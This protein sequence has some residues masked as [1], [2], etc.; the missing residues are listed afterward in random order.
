[1]SDKRRLTVNLSVQNHKGKRGTET[2]NALKRLALMFDE[3]YVTPPVANVINST[4]LEKPEH[5]TA[6]DGRRLLDASKFNYFRDTTE[7][8]ELVFDSFSNQELR[9]TLLVFREA[10]I[11]KTS[12]SIFDELPKEILGL[13]NRLVSYDITDK[14]FNRLSRTKPSDYGLGK[15]YTITLM[16]DGDPEKGEIVVHVLEDPPAVSDSKTITRELITS[17]HLSSVPVFIEQT[18]RA[19]IEYKYSQ[20]KEGLKILRKSH[21][22][23]L[24]ELD[25]KAKLGEVAFLVS[26]ELFDGGALSLCSPEEVVRY[27]SAMEEARLKYVSSDLVNVASMIKDGPWSEQSRMEVSKYINGKLNVDLKNYETQSKMTYRKFFGQLSTHATGVALGGGIGTLLGSVIPNASPWS[28][29]L[30]GSLVGAAR[31]G[32]QIVKSIVDMW[33]QK[34]NDRGSAI[35]F[36]AEFESKTS[37]KRRKKLIGLTD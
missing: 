37:I 23:A 1:M 26:N 4:F 20:Y 24:A 19:E 30:I 35:A 18:H 36:V 32:S 5:T 25:F 29:I 22:G 27:R 10:G 6:S 13:R 3:I 9:E 16:E 12:R 2:A 11:I 21:P 14:E 8:F 33:I 31:E 34:Q 7:A 15:I 28:L 17:E